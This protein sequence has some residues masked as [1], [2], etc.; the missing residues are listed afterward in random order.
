LS[1]IKTLIL[2][3][4]VVGGSKDYSFMVNK[5]AKKRT[6][7]QRIIVAGGPNKANISNKTELPGNSMHYFPKE[8]SL[9]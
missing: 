2:H 9:W 5:R 4:D 3:S 6:R 8:E 7:E 1:A